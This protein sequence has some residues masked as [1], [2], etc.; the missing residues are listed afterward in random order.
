M[1]LRPLV[2]ECLELPA[3]PIK[4]RPDPEDH[5]QA[6]LRRLIYDA[7]LCCSLEVEHQGT[8]V[9]YLGSGDDLEPLN[10]AGFGYQ[11]VAGV[12]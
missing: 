4:R 12:P 11:Q 7:F 1:A 8:V 5:A 6:G 2:N 10:G 3:A 9:G